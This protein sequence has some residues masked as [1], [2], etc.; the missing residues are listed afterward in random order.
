MARIII[1]PDSWLFFLRC[2]F[3]GA[4]IAASYLHF[5]NFMLNVNLMR[6]FPLKPVAAAVLI[7]LGLTSAVGAATPKAIPLDPAAPVTDAG[8]QRIAMDGSGNFATVWA[9]HGLGDSPAGVAFRRYNASGV[10]QGTAPVLAN[11]TAV[12]GATPALARNST[13]TVVVVWR[14]DI[15]VLAQRFAADGTPLGT[16]ITVNISAANTRSQQPRVGSDSIGNFIVVWVSSGSNLLGRLFS[17]DG[18]ALSDEIA[19]NDQTVDS[20]SFGDVAMDK[21][22]NF[23]VTW[24]SAGQV[25][26]R[27]FTA[28]GIASGA[29]IRVDLTPVANDTANPTVDYTLDQPVIAMDEAGDFAIAWHRDQA[30]TQLTVKHIPK[31]CHTYS[32]YVS[33]TSAYDVNQYAASTTS[34][35]R[36]RRYDHTTANLSAT[37]TEVAKVMFKTTY[38]ANNT[39]PNF[40]TQQDLGQVAIAMDQTGN[41]AVA[42]EKS[43]TTRKKHCYTSSGYTNCS[44]NDTTISLIQFRQYPATGKP[45]AA[46]V[47]IAAPS[48]TLTVNVAPSIALSKNGS[49][50]VDWVA[51]GSSGTPSFWAQFYPAKKK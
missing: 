48:K 44:F 28:T 13:G 46:A 3:F 41:F 27:R 25:R 19:L 21:N 15:H 35:I 2:Q 42:W 31:K 16:E 22:G 51:K 50:A 1:D 5:L 45:P 18:T 37:E 32:G 30:T 49:L 36:F 14:S 34:T 6:Q 7:G 8:G 12:S 4:L 33:C 11:Q 26:A 38:D 20:S 23:A 40:T 29:S 17:A 10:A 39:E 43:L 47:T 24:L 9:T